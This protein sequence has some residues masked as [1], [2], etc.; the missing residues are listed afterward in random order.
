MIDLAGVGPED[1]VDGALAW[2]GFYATFLAPL[3]ELNSGATDL[4]LRLWPS[5][6][7][8]GVAVLV[9]ALARRSYPTL[10]AVGSLSALI[11]VLL[12]WSGNDHFSPRSVGLLMFVALLVVVESGPLRSRTAWSASVPLLPRFSVSGGDRPDSESAVVFAA[13]IL[14]ALGA[15][16]THPVAPFYMITALAVLGLYGRRV[17]WRLLLLTAAV[18]ILWLLVAA[19][20]QLDGSFAS[21]ASL[22]GTPTNSPG[23]GEATNMSAEAGLVA[24]ARLYIG[25]AAVAS[26]LLIGLAMSREANR[27]L[28]PTVP[29]VPLGLAV[30]AGLAFGGLD[31]PSLVEVYTFALPV[32]AV[33]ISRMLAG[34]RPQTMPIVTMLAAIVLT[35]LLLLARYGG[36]SYE[37]AST[38]DRAAIESGY[39]QANAN[40]LFVA[41]NRFVAWGD[42]DRAGNGFL[43]E[44]VVSDEAWLESIKTTAESDGHSRIVV[45]LTESQQAW[46]VHSSGDSAT[47]LNDFAAWLASR[48][49]TALLYNEGAAWAIEVQP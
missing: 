35:P 46:R 28:R 40:T 13:M 32:A 42:H 23:S 48:P 17:A 27:H 44:P 26:A 36:E 30:A 22:F 2:P 33:L 15:V 19:R 49:D 8:G 38:A 24:N 10:P 21:F 47:S 12:A 16:T 25:L 41:D 1:S 4:I 9:A 11:Y 6:I 45:I 34:L 7:T 20:D 29:L 43:V 31:G 3:N 18:A 5:V 14:V 39:A 37:R